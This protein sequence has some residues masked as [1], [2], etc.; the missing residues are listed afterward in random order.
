MLYTVKEVA[1]LLPF[2][3]LGTYNVRVEALEEFLRQCEG[4]D[5][6]DPKSIK[7]LEREKY[8]VI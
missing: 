1:G 6:T 2:I 5:L 3:K 8:E 7:L 4:Y